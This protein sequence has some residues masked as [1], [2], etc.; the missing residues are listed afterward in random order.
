M[1]VCG[2]VLREEW[3]HIS[4]ERL[5]QVIDYGGDASGFPCSLLM[6]DED[7][8][9]TEVIGHC[10][11]TRVLNVEKA[12]YLE[13]IVVCRSRRG[14]G[15]GHKLL[16]LVQ[17]SMKS[18]G[19]SHT[20][21]SCLPEKSS[22][23]MHHGYQFCEPRV[24]TLGPAMFG[25]SLPPPHALAPPGSQMFYTSKMDYL[26]EWPTKDGS[27]DGGQQNAKDNTN[28]MLLLPKDELDRWEDMFS[29]RIRCMDTPVLSEFKYAWLY[30]QLAD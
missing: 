28:L 11:I 18:R 1:D 8:H 10:R 2:R 27:D 6:V 19:F 5:R 14:Q 3:P 17:Q 26:P 29:W 22:I 15:L 16:D 20:I 23:F 25:T 21:V 30:K 24:V 9:P 7:K 4:D 13:S 12:I